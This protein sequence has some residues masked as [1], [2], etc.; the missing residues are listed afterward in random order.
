V[1]LHVRR[2]V[3]EFVESPD[4]YCR[5]PDFT[6]ALTREA[7]AT[8]YLNQATVAQLAGTGALKVTGDA[9]A[10]DRVLALFDTFESPKPEQGR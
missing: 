2:G 8:L 4:R 10:A 7:W 1:G 5:R 6:L 9:A 3:V